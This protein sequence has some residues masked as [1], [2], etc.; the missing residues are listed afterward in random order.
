MVRDGA[1]LAIVQA[2]LSL[3]EPLQ[4][5]VVAEGVE[6]EEQLALLRRLG[7]RLAQGAFTGRPVDREA[8]PAHV[9][10]GW[11]EMASH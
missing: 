9:R 7:C 1:T 10:A 4:L 8:A 11:A 3:T 5:D 6:T 2:V